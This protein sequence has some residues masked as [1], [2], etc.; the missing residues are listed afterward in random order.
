LEKIAVINRNDR[1]KLE[2]SFSDGLDTV[3]SFKLESSS[4]D[5]Y[6]IALANFLPLLFSQEALS[7]DMLT[8]V[9]SEKVDNS[10]VLLETLSRQGEVLGNILKVVREFRDMDFSSKDIKKRYEERI[11]K[12]IQ[13]STIATYLLRLY[14]KGLLI[15]NRRGKEYVYKAT[16]ILLKNE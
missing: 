12:P 14:D 4:L 6:K 8:L 5:R 3:I 10:N 9:P 13:L 7:K 16:A 2:I 15:R 1:K 11:G